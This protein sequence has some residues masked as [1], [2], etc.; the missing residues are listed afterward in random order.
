MKLRNLTFF[1]VLLTVFLLSSC[2]KSVPVELLNTPHVNVTLGN[3]YKI[4]SK[5]NASALEIEFDRKIPKDAF[6]YDKNNSLL[7]VKEY[8][9]KTVVMFSKAQRDI[10]PG[11]FLFSVKKEYLNP[12]NNKLYTEAAL[13][14][15]KNNKI[16]TK[17]SAPYEDGLS[18]SDSIKLRT[19]DED[20]IFI[21]AKNI[22]NVET[23]QLDVIYPNGL[24]DIDTSKGTNGIELL[25][26]VEN[27][28]LSDPIITPG[29]LKITFLTQNGTTLSISDEDII[30]IHIIAKDVDPKGIGNV[31][32]NATLLDNNLNEINVDTHTG[33]IAVYDPILLGDFDD[34]TTPDNEKNNKVDIDDFLLFLNYYDSTQGDGIYNEEFDIYPSEIAPLDSW[35]GIYSISI[36][37]SK[38]NLYDFIIFAR[39]Y[40]KSLP[41]ENTPPSFTG[42][43]PNP[44]DSQTGVSITIALDFNDAT[45]PDGDTVKYDVYLSTTKTLVDNMDPTAKI[46]QNLT[47]S[48]TSNLDLERGTT[49]YWKAVAKDEKGGID[50]TPTYSFTT[51]SLDKVF[52]A[53]GNEG[54]FVVD[55]S[56]TSNPS[57]ENSLDIEGFVYDIVKFNGTNDKYIG[58]A[59]GNEGITVLYYD[60]D[61]A[62]WTLEEDNNLP[63][64]YLGDQ[65]K[66]IA[67]Y[68][69]GSNHYLLA[70]AGSAGLY[71]I[72]FTSSA[73]DTAG[74]DNPLGTFGLSLK[75]H[76]AISGDSNQITLDGTAAYI[77]AGNGGLAIVDISDLSNPVLLGTLSTIEA[78]DVAVDG[79][80]AYVAAGEN[81]VY[82]IDVSDK[83]NPSEVT[84]YNTLGFAE[85]ID[86][87]GEYVFVA[88]GSNGL[89][90]LKKDTLSYEGV[91]NT[92]GYAKGIS[93]DGGTGFIGDDY[94]GLN[95][96]DVN[97]LSLLGSLDNG[98]VARDVDIAENQ[99]IIVA[100]GDNGVK[101]YDAGANFVNITNPTLI[102]TI[103]TPGYA[104]SVKYV[105]HD[106][107]GGNEEYLIY[108]AN[109]PK[110]ISVIN[111]DDSDN[112]TPFEN[113]ADIDMINFG[114]PSSPKYNIDTDGYVYDVYPYAVDGTFDISGNEYLYVADGLGGLLVYDI[115]DQ[116]NAREPVFKKKFDTKGV[117]M[118]I[119]YDDD[120]DGSGN[121]ALIV[122]D[123]DNGIVLLDIAIPDDPSIPV[124]SH[125]NYN[126]SGTAFDLYVD[127][128]NNDVYVADGTQ[129]LNVVNYSYSAGPPITIT[130]SSRG[131]IKFDDAIITGI[132]QRASEYYQLAAG[133]RGVV[134]MRVNDPTQLTNADVFDSSTSDSDS[135]NNYIASEYNT[136][137]SCY[138]TIYKNV[139]NDYTLVADGENGLVILSDTG[140]PYAFTLEKDLDWINFGNIATN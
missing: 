30:K 53:G 114:T 121:P 61:G 137:G 22:S 86:V 67:Y 5:V 94:N 63:K 91:Y 7:F 24:I 129:G 76:L 128:A 111:A 56:T 100:D 92:A 89:V 8:S 23:F 122:A 84:S 50:Q 47:S 135:D 125:P 117:A 64:F 118:A 73:P 10:V 87:Q 107:G 55:V 27:T 37:D 52:I 113:A 69:D 51:E 70:A 3:D 139:T 49:Y 54:V 112:D 74:N 102:K 20:A 85:G 35:E 11:E 2:F 99:Y 28:L 116:T 15:E 71:I 93:V 105:K 132:E 33:D 98:S 41:S 43:S 57:I 13:F 72:K 59:R 46:E 26:S 124:P 110:G 12:E 58:V 120:Y 36:K 78:K 21:H 45:D 109:G 81:G 4:Q 34:P 140:A 18:V 68:Y 14:D 108:V 115:K 130:W 1:I 77:A 19:G 97:N 90:K 82:K 62:N 6:I 119:G 16:I 123:G 134:V 39:N 127:A 131:G 133:N 79:N 126:T 48:I 104:R 88:D 101:I 17:A 66:G 32:V 95:I 83:T 38:I 44:S 65:A 42:N 103:K 136:Q 40:S 75:S 138:S 60:Y 9:N 106:D 25:N 80:Y 29:K 31:T 96:I